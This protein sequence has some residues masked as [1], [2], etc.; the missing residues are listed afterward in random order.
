[1]DRR[2]ILDALVVQEPTGDREKAPELI[3][4][5]FLLPGRRPFCNRGSDIYSGLTEHRAPCRRGNRN[6]WIW[7]KGKRGN[8]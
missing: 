7:E 1:M 2:A 5:C 4:G 6:Q 3:S 8:E